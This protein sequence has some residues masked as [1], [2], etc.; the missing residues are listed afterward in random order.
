MMIGKAHQKLKFHKTKEA[1]Q[2]FFETFYNWDDTEYTNEKLKNSL[3][4]TDSLIEEAN[5]ILRVK[6]PQIYTDWRIVPRKPFN[7]DGVD[8]DAAQEIK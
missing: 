2:I 1:C 6:S 8:C 5:A 7:E 3:G 4:G